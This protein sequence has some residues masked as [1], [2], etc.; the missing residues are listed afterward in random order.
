ML[1]FLDVVSPIPEFCVIADNKVIFKKKIV[2]NESDKLSDH[3][4][5][6]YNSINSD[7]N[8]TENL[9]KIAM[10]IGPGS[11]TSL[12]VGAAFLSGLK[13]SKKLDF[14]SISVDDIFRIKYM[15]NN[16]KNFGIFIYSAKKQRFFCKKDKNIT[17]FI[18]LED[19][20][21]IIEKNIEKILY[22]FKPFE[23]SD[24]NIAQ[25]KFSF[26]DFLVKYNQYFKITKDNIIRPIYISNNKILN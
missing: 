4:I 17:S 13:I 5:E 8:L 19:E 22:N 1:L 10:T 15:I 12:R 26:I 24:C 16:E 3:I 7:L 21:N 23:A 18:K 11:Y 9:K 2:S 14:Y 20:K 6:S 25:Q